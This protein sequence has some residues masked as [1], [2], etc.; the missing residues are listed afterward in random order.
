MIDDVPG[1]I[2]LRLMA[3]A[4][5]W[6]RT[7]EAKRP[8]RPRIFRRFAQ[9]LSANQGIKRVLELGS[10]P[11]FLAET[12]LERFPTI[13]YVA[14]DFSAAM[15]QLARQRLERFAGRVTFVESSFRNMNWHTDLGK[16]DCV[17]TLQSVHELRH[18]SRASNLHQQVRDILLEPG[19]YVV[20]DHFAG[21]GGMSNSE[22]FMTVS[23]QELALRQAGFTN[24]QNRLIDGS[25]SLFV[26]VQ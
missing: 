1:S 20:C 11:G 15:H 16:F 26:T 10:G 3:D 24:V 17:V 21:D 7:A 9:C 4:V 8:Q 23:E 22:L 18:K 6:A 5:E 12:L 2:D 14:L 25:L 19:L 13:Q